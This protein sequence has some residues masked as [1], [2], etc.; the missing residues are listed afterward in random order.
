MDGQPSSVIGFWPMAGRYF[1]PCDEEQRTE[2]CG[3]LVVFGVSLRNY[4][5]ALNEEEIT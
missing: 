4:I 3:K 1:H 5:N 2:F